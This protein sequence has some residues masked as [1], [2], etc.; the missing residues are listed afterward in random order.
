MFTGQEHIANSRCN[1]VRE[2]PGDSGVRDGVA[3]GARSGREGIR[4]HA[5]AEQLLRPDHAQDANGLHRARNRQRC[6]RERQ[7]APQSLRLALVSIA[8]VF[9]LAISCDGRHQSPRATFEHAEQAFLHGQLD[10]SHDEAERGYQRFRNSSPEWALKFRILEAKA[11]LWQ[12]LYEDVLS[13]LSSE[14][15]P[16]DQPDLAI[17][18][19]TLVG[20][21]N[22]NTHNF[23]EAERSLGDASKLCATSVLASCGYVLQARGLLAS[24]R[25]QSTSAEEFYDL[26][27]AFARSHGDSFLESDSLLNLG[28]ESLSQERYDEAI[29]RSQAAYQAAKAADA[30][31]LEPIIQG[32]IGWAHYKLGDLDQALELFLHAGKRASD[33]HEFADQGAWL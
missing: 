13:L 14:S 5:Q 29:D 19:L 25:A 6:K 15:V 12:G 23:T 8:A 16:A 21:A 10:H 26:S 20:V 18:M 22:V 11:A 9:A 33:L 27:L 2:C 7:W 32:N 31:I 30:G 3:G 17:S 24:E 28:A 4:S 1:I